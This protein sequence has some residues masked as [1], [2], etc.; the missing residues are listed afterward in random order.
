MS[1]ERGRLNG[2]TVEFCV[3]WAERLEVLKE[4]VVLTGKDDFSKC[5]DLCFDLCDAL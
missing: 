2:K 1:E 4:R 3:L 5:F